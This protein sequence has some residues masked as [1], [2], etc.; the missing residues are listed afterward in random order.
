MIILTT[1]I[2]VTYV[3]Q[4]VTVTFFSEKTGEYENT[5]KLLVK[6]KEKDKCSI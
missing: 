6:N 3:L 5:R 4:S 1:A 2:I